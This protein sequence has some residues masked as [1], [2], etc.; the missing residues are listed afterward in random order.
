MKRLLRNKYKSFNQA[1]FSHLFYQ[2]L[3]PDIQRKLSTVKGMLPLDDLAK[4]ADDFMASIPPASSAVSNIARSSETQQLAPLVSQLALEIN[5]LKE[6]LDRQSRQRSRS[7]QP[8][9][10][11]SRSRS[12]PRRIPGVCC[13]RSRFGCDAKKCTTPCTSQD[14]P[15]NSSFER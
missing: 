4:L 3:P 1:M 11:S 12:K 9:R 8:H 10:Q 14:S 6:R 13:Y 15:L 7:H 2:L 5:I